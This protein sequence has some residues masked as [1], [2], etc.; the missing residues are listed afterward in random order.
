MNPFSVKQTTDIVVLAYLIMVIVAMSTTT[1]ASRTFIEIIRLLAAAILIAGVLRL[2]V[3]GKNLAS[4]RNIALTCI[5]FIVCGI[6][7]QVAQQGYSAE[8]TNSF[9]NLIIISVGAS[10]FNYSDRCEFFE[11]VGKYLVIFVFVIFVLTLSAD[12]LILEFPP[13]FNLEY[14]S[15]GNREEIYSLGLSQFFGIG[16]VVSAFLATRVKSILKINIYIGA[17]IF[18]ILLSLL[19]GGRGDSL[20]AVLMSFLLLCCRFPF[21]CISITSASLM[22]AWYIDIGSDIF[23]KFVLYQRLVGGGGDLGDRDV[24]LLQAFNLL[25]EQPICI[26]TGCGFSFFQYFYGY[27]LGM[28]P[29]NFIIEMVITFGLPVALMIF[30]GTLFGIIKD[31]RASGGLNLGLIIFIY[32]MLVGLK[33][34][35]LLTNWLLTAGIINYFSNILPKEGLQNPVSPRLVR[36]VTGRQDWSHG[37]DNT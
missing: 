12:G 24:L 8:L 27:D 5:A 23:E 18:F 30:A 4:Q 15:D 31:Y 28:Y 19:G 10:A 34:Q 13:R 16:G 20:L 25:A 2:L 3:K 21:G 35:S 6:G 17:S 32:S 11:G 7:L 1:T 37:T 29:H 14:L 9:Y 33:S 26:L 22:T 36:Y